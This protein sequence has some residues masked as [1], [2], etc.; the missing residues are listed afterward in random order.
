M[1]LFPPPTS[2][3]VIVDAP[4][5]P[6]L[7]HLAIA[8][9]VL[10]TSSHPDC[11]HT[12]RKT[13]AAHRTS[14][15]G[16]QPL[17]MGKQTRA[18]S[19]PRHW[20]SHLPYLTQPSYAPGLSRSQRAALATRSSEASHSCPGSG[21]E[22]ADIPVHLPRGPSANAVVVPIS[23]PSHPA[24]HQSGLFAAR[25]LPPGSFILP[26]Y[27]LVHS[28][29]PPH[30]LKH[31]SSDYDLWLDRDAS[32]AIDAA[33]MGN[34][35]RFINDYRGVKAKP[36]AEFRECWDGRCR[37]KCMAVFVLPS[38]KNANP[39]SKA[40]AGIAKGEEILVSYGKGF[41]GK[42]SQEADEAFAV[43]EQ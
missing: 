25:H 14:T 31:E 41:W 17:S 32:V 28:A 23:D 10:T 16:T 2:G 29:L 8:T 20:P 19:L 24:C 1:L 33:L 6:S 36:N 35:A 9:A 30:S 27:G 37:E 43:G 13:L 7:R 26:Y 15:A 4:V 18:T 3:F 11:L 12:Q 22:A 40:S 39:K 42:R 38:G 5:S 34:E 21:S